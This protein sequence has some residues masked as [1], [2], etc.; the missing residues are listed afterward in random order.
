MVFQ[1]KLQKHQYAEHELVELRVPLHLPYLSDWNDFEQYHGETTIN[2]NHY[3]FVKRKLEKGELVLL[4]I[5]N[6]QRDNISKAGNDYFKQ[7]NDL[8]VE[9]KGKNNQKLVKSGLNDISCIEPGLSEPFGS[10][11]KP[12]YCFFYQVLTSVEPATPTKPPNV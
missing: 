6:Q 11:L 7:V 12:K 10:T 1:D 9:K 4:C 2:G 8:P 3:R 5:R